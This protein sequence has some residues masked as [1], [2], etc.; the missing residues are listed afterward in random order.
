MFRFCSV[1]KIPRELFRAG[2][3]AGGGGLTDVTA[4][5][6]FVWR[7]SVRFI[8]SMISIQYFALGG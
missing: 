8:M 3:E 5:I 4:L 1:Y 2:G 7:R 6:Q